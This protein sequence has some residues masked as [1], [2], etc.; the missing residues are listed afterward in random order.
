[1]WWL[2]PG[3]SGRHNI[4]WLVLHFHKCGTVTEIC[5]HMGTACMSAEIHQG[6]QQKQKCLKFPHRFILLFTS[7]LWVFSRFR[8]GTENPS[9]ELE[10]LS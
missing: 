10:W 6:Q 3:L 1:M 5:F 8:K 4:L 7:S 2:P 9:F